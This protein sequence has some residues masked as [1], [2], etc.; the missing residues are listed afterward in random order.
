MVAAR[1]HADGLALVNSAKQMAQSVEVLEEHTA[2]Q[3]LADY[4]I[5]GIDRPNGCV[6]S[7]SFLL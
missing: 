1:Q 3:I 7:L 5:V 2:S 6:L 4:S